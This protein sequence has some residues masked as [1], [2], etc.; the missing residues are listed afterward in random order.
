MALDARKNFAY[1]TIATAPVT[2]TAGTSLVV[3][4]GDG[5]KF[6]ATPFNAVIWPTGQQPTATNA[7]IVRVTNISTDTF[8]I[9]RAQ[10]SSPARTVIV[11]DQI[12]AGLTD[13]SLKD[14]EDYLTGVSSPTLLTPTIASL[15]NAQHT[16]TNAAGGGTIAEGA[17][18]MTDITTNDASSTKHGFLKKLSNTAGQ[19]FDALGNWRALLWSDLPVGAAV[20]FVYSQY[21]AAATGTT[22]TPTDGTIPQITEGDQYMSQTITPKSTTN[23]LVINVYALVTYSVP[24]K[25]IVIALHQDSVANALA[26][27]MV[28]S[29]STATV[30]TALKLTYAM[31]AGTTSATTFKVRIGAEPAAGGTLS[32]NVAVAVSPIFGAS[33]PKSGIWITEYNA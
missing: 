8:T 28:F 25:D 6:P 29:P 11:G 31:P 20:Q 7:E 24:S 16:H 33:I 32:F 30:P 1:S 19:F 22:T 2:P 3:A 21:A 27:D 9:T 14:I 23:I 18:A 17:L 5:T 26:A 4:S 15:T 12:M 13:K 10:E